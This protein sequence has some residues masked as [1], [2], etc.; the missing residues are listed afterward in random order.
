MGNLKKKKSTVKR[1]LNKNKKEFYKDWGKAIC[2][3]NEMG[4]SG[5]R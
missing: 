2:V 4:F 5:T 3:V 1:Y